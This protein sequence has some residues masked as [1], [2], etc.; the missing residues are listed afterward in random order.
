MT[1]LNALLGNPEHASVDSV[2]VTDPAHPLFGQTFQVL[3]ISRGTNDSSH[4]FVRYRN[5]IT[6]RIPR[7]MTSLATFVNDE[8]RVRLCLAAVHEFLSLVKEYESCPRRQRKSGRRL[9][10]HSNKRSAT[11]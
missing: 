9:P 4:V 11:S 10:R 6:L 1:F 2:E 5:D 3:S 8:P 7:R